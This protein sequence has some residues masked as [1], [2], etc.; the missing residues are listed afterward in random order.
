MITILPVTHNYISFITKLDKFIKK[1]YLLS[2]FKHIFIGSDVPVE[3]I[4]DLFLKYV[5]VA[6]RDVLHFITTFLTE[7]QKLIFINYILKL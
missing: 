5:Q 1:Q 3:T 4:D 6:N 2:D 7:P